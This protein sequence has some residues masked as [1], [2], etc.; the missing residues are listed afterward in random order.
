M[1]R[2]NNFSYKS[3]FKQFNRRNNDIYASCYALYLEGKS[4]EYI[5]KVHYRGRFTRQALFN[6]FKARGYRLRSKNF[7]K[8]K[9]YN[10]RMFR[11]D[12]HGLYRARNQGKAIYLH[13]LIWEEA[14]GKIPPDYVVIFKDGDKENLAI[15]NLS[16]LHREEAKRLYNY[17]NQYGYKR[18][19]GKGA[20]G[21]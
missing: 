18:F 19:N 4:L 15:E 14:N 21:K 7:G 12:K 2:I 9:T 3:E 8:A 5:A 17:S 1:E 6:V 10:G 13:R 20:F 16:C 11:I